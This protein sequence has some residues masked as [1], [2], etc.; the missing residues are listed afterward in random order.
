MGESIQYSAKNNYVR[1]F[2]VILMSI[3]MIAVFTSQIEATTVDEKIDEVNNYN[4]RPEKVVFL[5]FDDG[6]ST[7]TTELLAI[8]EE[9]HVPAIFFILGESIEV[10]PDSHELIKLMVNKG[11]HLGL[12]SM[13]HNKNRLYY[14]PDSPQIFVQE[15]LELK[16]LIFDITDGYET[17]LCRAPHGN[18]Y[19]RNSHWQAV[20]EAGLYCLGW[21]VDSRD[22]QHQSHQVI[23]HEVVKDLRSKEFPNKVVLLF[24]EKE[25]T[26]KALPLIINYFKE[27]EYSFVPFMEGELIEMEK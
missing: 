9:H 11:H 8:L 3:I 26:I 12:H 10:I 15:M 24:H 13:S 21:N 6:P 18:S 23:F 27:M 14:R 25:S 5:T 16:K 17:S 22:W 20:E 7:Y 2:I 4:A 19:L 1:Q